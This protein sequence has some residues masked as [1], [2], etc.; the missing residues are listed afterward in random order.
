MDF[1][2]VNSA[3]RDEI[4]KRAIK[5]LNS[6]VKKKDIAS[7][8]GVN[9]NTVTNWFKRYK[10]DGLKGLRDHK[11]GVS[12]ASK[13]LLNESQEKD[14]QLM[15]TD[16][17]PDQL[18]LD[19]GLW[20]RKAVKELV[21]REY[22]IILAINT[23]GDYLRSWG[24]SPQKPKKQAYEQCSKKVQQWLDLTYPL[25]K[26]R[27]KKEGGEIQWGD[28]TGVRNTNQHGRSYASKGKTPVKKSMSKRFSVN[29]ISSVANQGNVRFMIYSGTMNADRCILS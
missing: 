17:M 23:M 18:K 2:T 10:Q 6:G 24:F 9:P 5:Q 12:S 29:M 7:L 3:T 15:I 25:I 28:E 26:E 11:R 21:E 27:A 13:K 1:R 4:R 20:T 19:Y 8:Y 14:I 22:G 16:V